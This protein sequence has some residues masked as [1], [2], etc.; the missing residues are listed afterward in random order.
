ML[1]WIRTLTPLFQGLFG[2]AVAFA[3]CWAMWHIWEDHVVYHQLV[4]AVI[5]LQQQVAALTPKK[6]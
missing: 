5:Q 3:A 1:K 2:G 4:N 6:P